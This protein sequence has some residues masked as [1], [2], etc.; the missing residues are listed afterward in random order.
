M[1]HEVEIH[2]HQVAK[3]TWTSNTRQR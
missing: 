1:S 3:N 2:T